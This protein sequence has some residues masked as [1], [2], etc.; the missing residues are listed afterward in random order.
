M[1]LLF[2]TDS[3][4]YLQLPEGKVVAIRSEEISGVIWPSSEVKIEQPP[5]PK[6]SPP[7]SDESANLARSAEDSAQATAAVVG[8]AKAAANSA[9]EASQ[10]AIEAAESAKT[11]AMTVKSYADRFET[12]VQAFRLTF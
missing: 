7:H 8:S 3:Y 4:W 6:P 2:T 1:K 10:K 11:S 5:A 9:I 12:H